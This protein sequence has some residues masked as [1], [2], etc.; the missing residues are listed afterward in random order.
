MPTREAAARLCTAWSRRTLAGYTMSA[1]G[2]DGSTD[3]TLYGVT[4]ADKPWIQATADRLTVT[5]TDAA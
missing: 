4:D 1:T 5:P 2:P 3:V